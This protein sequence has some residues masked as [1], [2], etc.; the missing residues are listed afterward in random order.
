MD[1]A[2]PKV[3]QHERV[4]IQ[5]DRGILEVFRRSNVIGPHRYPLA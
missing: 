4:H 5:A 2:E 3:F 1:P